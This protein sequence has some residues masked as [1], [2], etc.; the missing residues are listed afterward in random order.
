M[1]KNDKEKEELKMKKYSYAQLALLFKAAGVPL[2]KSVTPESVLKAG[3]QVALMEAGGI[4]S[5]II[6][7]QTGAN[8]VIQEKGNQGID[9]LHWFLDKTYTYDKFTMISDF[10]INRLNITGKQA[11][12]YKENIDNFIRIDRHKMSREDL[13]IHELASLQAAIALQQTGS[14]EIAAT[15]FAFFEV[16]LYKQKTK[17]L[18]EGK[19]ITIANLIKIIPSEA[20]EWIGNAVEVIEGN[21]DFN[22]GEQKDSSLPDYIDLPENQKEN[23]DNINDIDNTEYDFE[24][25]DT[26]NAF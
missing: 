5:I 7:E 9:Y 6:L 11:D 18:N 16:T 1:V 8:E 20:G 23:I 14:I 26:V 3:G 17:L 21:V 10:V 15:T 25:F 13:L 19:E 22:F 12:K 24:V 4:I 2:P